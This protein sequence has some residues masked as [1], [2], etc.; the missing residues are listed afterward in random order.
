MEAEQQ[1]HLATKDEMVKKLYN[2]LASIHGFTLM[3]AER[4][5]DINY[6]PAV[7]KGVAV[8]SPVEEVQ[9]RIT[10]AVKY[11]AVTRQLLPKITNE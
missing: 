9:L 4:S 1:L 11:L 8:S 10:A 5:I 6:G 7:I 3:A 2:K